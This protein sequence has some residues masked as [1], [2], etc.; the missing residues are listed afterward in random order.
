[1]SD[2]QQLQEDV[3][4]LFRSLGCDADVDARVQGIRALHKIDVWVRFEHFSLRHQWVIECKNW[5][6]PVPK[7]KILAL[8]SQIDD[9]GADRGILIAQSG[10]QSG[11]WRAAKSTNI[12]LMDI[13]ELKAVTNDDFLR[14]ALE[15]LD[16]KI[17]ILSGEM[18]KKLYVEKNPGSNDTI[19]YPNPAF[20]QKVCSAAS[21]ELMTLQFS[22]KWIRNGGDFSIIRMKEDKPILEFFDDF[23][24]FL[25]EAHII[26][27]RVEELWSQQK[28]L[29]INNSA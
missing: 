4:G 8:K 2:W 18:T 27:R 29:A 10:F 14:I 5:R 20:N 23:K 28:D 3:A 1:M 22:I 24:D 17:E 21:S 6:K 26:V 12:D 25:D 11:A 16:H 13:E 15:S 7:E 19:F 9:I